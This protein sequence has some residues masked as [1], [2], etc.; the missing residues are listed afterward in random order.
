MDD[1][2]TAERWKKIDNYDYFVSTCG[3][4]KN[5]R[6]RIIKQQIT[7][8]GRYRIGLTNMRMY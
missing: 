6:D 2:N 8:L 3:R 7:D 4:V 5:K 1:D